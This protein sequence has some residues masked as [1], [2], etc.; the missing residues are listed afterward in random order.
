MTISMIKKSTL[1]IVTAFLLHFL[2]VYATKPVIIASTATGE[3][4]LE[5]NEFSETPALPAKSNIY[6]SLKLGKL[7]LTRLAFDQA[8]NGFNKLKAQGRLNKDHI[9]S[10]ADFSLASSKKRLFILDLKNYKIL[11]NTYV[12]HGRNSGREKA[13]QFS[14]QA[15]SFKSSLGFYVTS[16]TYSG[17]H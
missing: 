17:K 16:G 11:Y 5:E 14:N 9:I 8:I 1:C 15:E 12:S 7:G 10:I 3:L 2:F 4:A 13:T 6:D